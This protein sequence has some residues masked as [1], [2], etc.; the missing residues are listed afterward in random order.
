MAN[1]RAQIVMNDDEASSFLRDGRTMIVVTNGADGV[2]D[3]VPMWYVVDSDGSVLMR[4]YTKSRK[5][6]NL[7]RD[8]RYSALVE[9]GDR[10][11]DLRGLQLTGKAELFDDVELILDVVAGLAVKYEELALEHFSSAREAARAVASKWTGIRL[12]VDETVSWDHTK[13]GGSY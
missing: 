4:T 10:Y 7:L 5:I 12:Q 8:P 6:Q 13:L 11:A 1:R 3:P 2:P 9:T